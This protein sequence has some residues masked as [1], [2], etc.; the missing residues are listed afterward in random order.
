MEFL[1]SL[2]PHA[3]P[4]KYIIEYTTSGG[5]VKYIPLPYNP[6]QIRFNLRRW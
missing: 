5:D 1:G 4:I 3:T 2:N 6:I